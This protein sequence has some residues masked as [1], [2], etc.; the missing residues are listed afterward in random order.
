MWISRDQ[1]ETV[2]GHQVRLGRVW[3]SMCICANGQFHSFPIQ[4][5]GDG[6]Q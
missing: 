2:K 3:G 1:D 5:G 6:Q 4:I